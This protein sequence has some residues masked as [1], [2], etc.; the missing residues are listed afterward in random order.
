MDANRDAHPDD[1]TYA[2]AGSGYKLA[3]PHPRP[4]PGADTPP[5]QSRSRPAHRYTKRHTDYPSHSDG[6]NAPHIGASDRYRTPSGHTN[7]AAD[8]DRKAISSTSIPLIDS[9]ST[10]VKIKKRWAASVFVWDHLLVSEQNR[11]QVWADHV[12]QAHPTAMDLLKISTLGD[13]THD[14]PDIGD[15]RTG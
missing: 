5:N 1:N 8:R 11:L 4:Y 9:L 7:P 6:D 2:H 3:I 10:F 13:T 14:P 12:Y 15:Q